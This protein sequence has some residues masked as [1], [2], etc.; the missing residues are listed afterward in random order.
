MI[1]NLSDNNYQD[2]YS[3]PTRNKQEEDEQTQF[4]ANQRSANTGINGG[5]NP[6]APAASVGHDGT[7][8]G[9]TREQWRDSWMSQG[10]GMTQQQVDQWMAQNGATKVGD[11]GTFTTPFG[12]NLDLGIGYK[13]GNVSAGW[14]P[15]GSDLAAVNAQSVGNPGAGANGANGANG[16]GMPNDMI[17]QMLMEELQGLR[18]P[19]DPN[20]PRIRDQVTAYRNDASRARDRGQEAMAERGAYSGLPSGAADTSVQGSYEKMGQ[21]VGNFSAGLIG[22]EYQNRRD[23][24]DRLMALAV[25]TGDAASARQLQMAIQTMDNQYRYASMGQQN[26][27]YYDNLDW[28]RT[29]GE[30]QLNRGLY[31]NLGN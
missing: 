3:N 6:P 10:G 8:N 2:D 5:A 18:G 22:K 26:Q 25:Q 23:E 19:V 15:T 7:Y 24:L 1:D 16:T 4:D 12:E 28:Q 27:Q 11:N 17:H 31:D 20:D 14:T 29:L 13:S 9:K 30:E 21:D